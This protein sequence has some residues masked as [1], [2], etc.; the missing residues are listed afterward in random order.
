MPEF[1]K[2]M[3][4]SNDAGDGDNDGKDRQKN[5]DFSPEYRLFTGNDLCVMNHFHAGIRRLTMPYDFASDPHQKNGGAYETE[6]KNN[7]A[8]FG[9]SEEFLDGAIAQ[10]LQ[11]W[12]QDEKYQARNQKY[13]YAVSKKQLPSVTRI[14]L[15]DLFRH[16]GIL[17]ASIE[18]N[19]F[20]YEKPSSIFFDWISFPR[21]M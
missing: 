3:V 1:L 17:L 6:K 10:I 13:P 12:R 4:G 21:A 15:D 18:F 19:V 5:K 7:D 16:G 2:K 9:Y 20:L 14:R 11:Q 8:D